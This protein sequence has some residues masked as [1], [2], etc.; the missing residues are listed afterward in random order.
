MARG[1]E[2]W[3]E[4]AAVEPVPKAVP[5]GLLV[6]LV[7]VGPT[8]FQIVLPA[9]P[10][11]RAAFDAPAAVTQ[12]VVS[13][14]LAAI[15]AATLVYGRVSD[16]VG[17][18]PPLLVGMALLIVGSLACA[19]APSIEMLI[20]GRAVQAAGAASGMVIARAVVLDLYGRERAREMQATLGAAM[21]AAPLVAAPLGGFLVD[22]LGWRSTFGV[23][24][25]LGASNLAAISALMRETGTRRSS[26][27]SVVQDYFQLVRNRSFDGYALQPGFAMGAMFAFLTGAPYVFADLLRSSATEFGVSVLAVTCGFLIGNLTASRWATR[28]RLDFAIVAGSAIALA[29]SAAGF[30]LA[31]AHVWT[32]SALVAPTA[33]LAFATGLA[34]PN[35]QAGAVSVSPELAG[36][37]SGLSGCVNTVIGAVAAQSAGTFGNG[38]PLPLTIVMLSCCSIAFAVSFL[39]LDGGAAER[40]ATPDRGEPVTTR[41]QNQR[42]PNA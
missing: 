14:S 11:W 25:V 8:S 18:K 39:T 28:M 32:A 1:P 6:A 2:A 41:L 38:T 19:V 15:A 13:L 3:T 31:L 26:S 17:R 37:A 20:I 5:F 24:A 22:R 9:L 23:V 12:L 30:L 7:A 35:A 42:V 16:R 29:A 27:R 40:A 4:G 36:N 33:V 21:M 34:L 10:V